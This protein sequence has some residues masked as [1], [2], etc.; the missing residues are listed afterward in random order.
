V[1]E[2]VAACF[3]LL[4]AYT[5]LGFW[6]D[7]IRRSFRARFHSRLVARSKKTIKCMLEILFRGCKQHQLVYE[8]Q[9]VDPE[10]SNS[11][12]L[13]D[14]AV[15]VSNLYRPVVL[16]LSWFVAPFQRLSTLVAP[17][18]SIEI[19]LSLAFT[20]GFCNITAELFAKTSAHGSRRT[21]S[22]PPREPR[23]AVVKP[24]YRL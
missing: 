2:T 3:R 18:S 4:A 9:T 11:E 10:V 17:C 5:G 23:A 8:K 12:T 6:R 19:P 24:W 20:L 16:N 13:V 15:P 7:T 21:A 22:W 14:S 1:N